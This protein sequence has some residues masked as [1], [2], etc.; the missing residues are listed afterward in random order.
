[1]LRAIAG[2][3]T[4]PPLAL[5]RALARA[6]QPGA[7]KPAE[8]LKVLDGVC[9]VIKPGTLTLVIAPPGHGKSA[10]LKALCRGLPAGRRGLQG[11]VTYS[12]VSAR[13]A[14]AVGVN[15]GSLVQYVSQLDDHIPFLTVR[16]TLAF[17]HANA[18]V[19]AAAHGYP[20]LAGE[21]ASAVDEV[22]ALLK[23][24]NAQSTVVGNDLL[25]GVSGGEKKR[26]TVGEGIITPARFLALDEISTGL[27]SAVTHDIVRSLKARAVANGLGVVVSLLQPTPE[28]YGLFDE[29]ILMREGATVF[30]GPR[31]ALPGYLAGLGVTLP[32][33]VA[34]AAAAAARARSA[35]RRRAA[36]GR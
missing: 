17:I 32:H 29:V 23:L 2:I 22:I 34:A 33:A 1:V 35:A 25:R 26:V 16:E 6:R 28:V 4:G 11:T 7:A 18:A 30:P 3:F 10:F 31:D 9:G 36:R 20:H 24:Q 19:D 14:R 5:V 8:T 15:L 13:D 27:D 21:H 12:G